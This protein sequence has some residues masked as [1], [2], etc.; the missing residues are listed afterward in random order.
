MIVGA[1]A[2][3]IHVHGSQS[4]KAKRGVVRSIA[5]RVRN[6]F[7]LSVAEVGGQDTWQIA[8]LGFG[9]VGNDR[10]KVREI[11]ERAVAFVEELHLAE[12]MNSDVELIDLPYREGQWEG[13]ALD[14]ESPDSTD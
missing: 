12:V 13:A 2:V 7:N 5:Q 11:L 8:V 4:L 10:K 14:L 6:R 9:T 3:E 1:A